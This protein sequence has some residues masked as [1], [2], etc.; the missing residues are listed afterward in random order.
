M[1]Y[2]IVL[3]LTALLMCFAVNPTVQAAD[4]ELQVVDK[5]CWIEIFEDTKYDMD[6]P[7]VK[8]MGPGEFASL[9][10]LSGRDWNNDVDSIIVGPNATVW[11]Y[12]DKD[13]KGTELAF[14]P[15]QRVPD[16]SKLKMGND[17]ESLK[18]KCGK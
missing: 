16:L 14:T 11:A 12:K 5:D 8:I 15:G 17:I 9:K 18:I 4:L 6:D 10:D 3:G 7:H 2:R 1:T 13:F